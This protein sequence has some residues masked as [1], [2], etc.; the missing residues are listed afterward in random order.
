MLTTRPDDPDGD[1]VPPADTPPVRPRPGRPREAS[2][3]QRLHAAV[4]ELLRTRGPAAVTIDAVTSASGVAKTSI[5]RRY[6]NRAELLTA[7]LSAAIGSPDVPVEGDVRGKIRAALDQVW[8]QM[9]HVLGPGGLAAIVGN[10][11]PEFTD[12]F[13]AALRPYVEALVGRIRDDVAGGLLRPDL[14]A[15]GVVSLMVGAYLGEL[16][17]HGGVAPDWLDRS[18]EMLWVL[19]ARP[20]RGA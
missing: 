12:L 1:R 15:E 5:Y 16:V 18:L 6:A 7:V 19:M 9:G 2:L 17:R 11:D 8:H 3:D 20:A 4:L 13:R 14:D 10:T